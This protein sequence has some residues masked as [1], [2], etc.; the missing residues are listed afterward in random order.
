MK[1]RLQ[2]RLMAVFV[3]IPLG[4]SVLFGLFAWGVNYTIEDSFLDGVL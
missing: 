2:R 4:V 3:A 1:Q